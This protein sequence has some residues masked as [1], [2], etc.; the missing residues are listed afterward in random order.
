MYDRLKDVIDALLNSDGLQ[1]I[2]DAAARVLKNPFWIV[3]MNS[4]FMATV[5]GE[6][7]NKKLLTESALGYVSVETLSY[8]VDQK[9]REIAASQ[10]SPHRFI[11]PHSNQEIITCPV[12]ID[13]T[14][15]AYIS[16]TAEYL[17]F[18]K[19]SMELLKDIARII[20]AE[21]QKN[22]FYRNNKSMMYS[23]FLSDLLEN[24]IEY[25]DI[26][27]RLSLIGYQPL[28]Y[29]YLL[30]VEL[31]NVES[32]RVV[33]NS[34][35]SQL[36]AICRNS[37]SCFYQNHYIYLLST[38]EELKPDDFM[39]EQLM[40]F[41]WDSNLKAVISDPFRNITYVKRHYQKTLQAFP[42]GKKF[43][44]D[45][46]LYNYSTLV[47][48]HAIT[49]LATTMRYSDF[50]NGAID[51][52]LCHDREHHSDYLATVTAFLD[53]VCRI[54]PAARALG[55]HTNTMRM[56]LEKIQEITQISFENG[57]QVFELSLALQLYL[58]TQSQDG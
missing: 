27:K 52:L 35:N 4:K 5:S 44:P 34:I 42:L 21:L 38:A 33:L 45:Q 29:F 3:D 49:I 15:V 36:S 8:T 2:S 54:A 39:F 23:Y 22:A 40:R 47:V 46:C 11:D 25:R 55:I 41:L 50:S 17:P 43:F 12:R 26:P 6:T 48:N 16:S 7:H 14:I 18:D 20:S 58:K 13:S 1:A 19:D 30:N 53:H 32:R 9:V 57:H 51:K 37:I 10:D 56:R 24:Q 31:P 28:Q